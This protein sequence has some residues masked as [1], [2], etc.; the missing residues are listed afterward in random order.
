MPRELEKKPRRRGPDKKPRRARARFGLYV[1]SKNGLRARDHRVVALTRKMQAAMPWLS[2][3]DYPAMRSWA[4]L[5]IL[6]LG[7]Y[8]DL[9]QRGIFA[10][11]GF[12]P[13]RLLTEY[14]QLR[15]AQLSYSRELGL[16][17]LAR[18]ELQAHSTQ[19]AADLPARLA[20]QRKAIESSDESE[21]A[22]IAEG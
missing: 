5:E 20:K 8:A 1:R 6:S 12:E 2:D 4:Q 15:S 13:R 19:V 14:R 7:V 16:T 11:G 21:E 22:E 9:I 10:K 3:S 17:A 18:S